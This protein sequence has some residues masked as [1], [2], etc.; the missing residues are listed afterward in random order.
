[1]SDAASD[2]GYFRATV[3]FY[4]CAD[5]AWWFAQ[6]AWEVVTTDGGQYFMR[7][8]CGELVAR[9]GH[10]D[11]K[12]EVWG[13]LSNISTDGP[14]VA[15]MMSD[16]S[17]FLSAWWWDAGGTALGE[18]MQETMAIGTQV[19]NLAPRDW[20]VGASVPNHSLAP[21]RAGG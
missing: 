14:A 13:R 7:S 12:V 6:A 3:P 17:T 20:R 8:Q 5:V 9:L 21:E 19:R 1:M 10:R 16:R 2:S 11:R 4:C 18:V 15:K